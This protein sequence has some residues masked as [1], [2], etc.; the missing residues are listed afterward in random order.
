[1][2][3]GYDSTTAWITTELWFHEDMLGKISLKTM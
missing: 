1:M 3:T 2:V